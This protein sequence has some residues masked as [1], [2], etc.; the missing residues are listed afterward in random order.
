MGTIYEVTG[1]L[2][3]L[4]EI[5]DEEDIDEQALADT[6]EGLEGEFDAKI[7]S[8]CK[9]IKNLEGEQ[10]AIKEE[11]KRLAERA[12]RVE[13]NIQ[14]IKRTML[15]CM[16]AVGKKTA[17]GII[18]ASVSKNG[19]LRPLLIQEG[20]DPKDAPELLRKVEYSLDTAAI[21]EALDGGKELGFAWYGERGEHITIK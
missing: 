4:I 8:L 19:S 14:R 11:S 21:R 12:K 2:L 9:V 6:L 1:E 17:G 7:E 5:A 16:N 3:A 10:K 15:V 20:F 18:K 13:N